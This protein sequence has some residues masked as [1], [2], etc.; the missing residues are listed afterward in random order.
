MAE[1]LMKKR[2]GAQVYVQSAGVKGDM[3]INGF[4]ISV[5]QEIGVELARHRVRSFEDMETGGE[6]L[7]GF[8][9][10]VTLSQASHERV[11]DLIRHHHLA[12]EYWPITDPTE[13]GETHLQKLDAFRQTRDQIW[14]QLHDTWA[15]F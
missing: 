14:D 11:Q 5:C 15:V 8:D 6:A 2:F 9:L 7:S 12:V 13:T 4:A 1:G 10:I 3:E